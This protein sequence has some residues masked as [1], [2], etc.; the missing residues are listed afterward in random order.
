MR[1]SGKSVILLLG[2][3]GALIS[4]Y[5]QN[6]TSSAING[7]V[8]DAEGYPLRE[9]SI[10]AVHSP[11]GTV[12]RTTTREN[13]RFNLRGMRVGGPYHLTVSALG[14]RTEKI[15]GVVLSLQQD[16]RFDFALESDEDESVVLEEFEVVAA[17]EDLIFSA[18]NMGAGTNIAG[19]EIDSLPTVSRSLTDFARLD[20]RLNVFD[21]ETGA[22]SSGGQNN[23]Y[24]SIMI[25]GV[26]TN[27]SFG[28]EENGLP[29]LTQP[30]SLDTIEEINVENSPYT[31]LQAGFTGAAINAITKSGTNQFRGSFYYFFR[32]EKLTGERLE[33]S[34][35]TDGPE[36]TFQDLEE[37]SE[38]TIGFT[39]GGPIFKDKLFFFASAERFERTS[40][41]PVRQFDPTANELQKIIDLSAEYGFEA[42]TLEAPTELKSK[43]EKILMKL[44]W[45]LFEDH[46]LTF[47][48]TLNN[49]DDPQFPSYGGDRSTSLSS[50]WY[51]RVLENSSYVAEVFSNWSEN[52]TTEAKLSFSRFLRTRNLSSDGPQVEI[53]SVNGIDGN[54]GSVRFGRETNGHASRLEVK[55]TIFQLHAN[56]FRGN[57]AFTFGLNVE[58]VANDNLFIRDHRG[59]WR[60]SGTTGYERAVARPDDPPHPP[61]SPFPPPGPGN[62]DNYNVSYPVQGLSGA[63]EWA[64]TTYAFFLQD[65]WDLSERLKITSG[66]RVDLPTVGDEIPLNEDFEPTFDRNHTGTVDGN[67]VLQPRFGFNWSVDKERKTQ[68]RGGVGLFYGTAPHV[69]LSNP[70]VSNGVTIL[71]SSPTNRNTPEF[72]A[73]GDN[74]PIPNTVLPTNNVDL[75][76]EVFEMPTSLKANLAL[77]RKL[78]LWD[79]KLS[80]EA[81]WSWTENDIQYQHLNLAQD[82]GISRSSVTG[83]LPDGRILFLK[84]DSGRR[85]FREEGF[86]NV[87]LLRNTGLGRSANY[88]MMLKKPKKKGFS[89]SFGYTY[90]MAMSVNDGRGSSASSI[91]AANRAKNPNDELEATSVFEVR[92]RFI[93]VATYQIKWWEKLKTTLSVVYDGRTG[94]P[95]S[96]TYFRSDIN[97][98][99][100]FVND[101]IY[102][103]S[104]REDPLVQ[105]LRVT[106][107]DAFWEFVENTKGLNL[108]RGQV[109]PRN[110][111]RAAW[112][113]QFDFK[114]TQQITVF[115]RHALELS[116][117]VLNI[118]NLINHDWGLVKRAQDGN[119]PFIEARHRADPSGETNGTF[120]YRF[121]EALLEEGRIFQT[122]Q[123]SSRW[124][125]LL[126]VKYRFQLGNSP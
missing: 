116:A 59:R 85:G 21:R 78:P 67:Y 48:Y 20:P 125:V 49:G 32:D 108:F 26:P 98:D 24:N 58:N 23:R 45:N 124:S 11:T 63:A 69:W 118:G 30:F 100:N 71:N 51:A 111:G 79:L 103:P 75:L 68:L 34:D 18:D 15:E 102:V 126:G 10:R 53:S 28:L 27:E 16:H 4:V 76:D 19:D 119:F 31:V 5:G 12:F 42:G 60:F 41:A 106:E 109:V 88:T 86:D 35:K 115:K 54:S 90:G 37:F 105:F 77:D 9:A 84:D 14:Y 70:F 114:V 97:E 92:H 72:S 36:G 74:P 66:V 3:C 112:V 64:L 17:P 38:K 91:W 110:T 81:Q 95:F 99:S 33:F 56:Y 57:H 43:D 13:G 1:K 80:L 6:I 62:A 52:F 39:V 22:L 46:R 94:R 65:T 55:T 93:G 50:H 101:L 44:D 82:L 7:L 121:N 120:V 104:S 29:A 73:D 117:A 61:G 40:L 96:Y 47:R 2:F 8:A 25:D 87:F 107:E 83:L 113:H 89:W 123:L 122:T